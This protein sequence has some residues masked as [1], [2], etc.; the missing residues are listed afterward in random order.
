MWLRELKRDCD[1]A[2][3]QIKKDLKSRKMRKHR[4]FLLD[5]LAHEQ[6]IR[7]MICTVITG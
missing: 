2:I 7:D 5:E 4:E 3:V 1:A 6:K